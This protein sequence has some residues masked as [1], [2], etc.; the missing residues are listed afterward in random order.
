MKNS[1]PEIL[2]INDDQLFAEKL[3]CNLSSF[4]AN[5][6]IANNAENGSH[7]VSNVEPEVFFLDHKLPKLEGNE[8]ITL[9]K[10][11]SPKS[12]II[13]MSDQFD[14]GE[15]VSAIENKADYILNKNEINNDKLKN[16]IE[17]LTQEKNKKQSLW[18]Y[19]LPDYSGS[20]ILSFIRKLLAEMKVII[21]SSQNVPEVTIDLFQK[22]ISGYVVK[23]NGWGNRLEECIKKLTFS[24]SNYGL[25]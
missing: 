6:S 25:F 9:Y 8:V 18:N 10:E 16:T 5:V 7:F 20:D 15:V 17:E 12:K 4:S 14:M 24:P 21:I 19:H 2:I 23:E 1:K 22:N 3:K 11:L 13:L